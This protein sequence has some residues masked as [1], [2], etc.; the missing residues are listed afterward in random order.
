M[1]DATMTTALV[2][3]RQEQ[4]HIAVR[5]LLERVAGVHVASLVPDDKVMAIIAAVEK[6]RSGAGDRKAKAQSPKPDFKDPSWVQGV[7]Y[8]RWNRAGSAS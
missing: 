3:L 7:V 8:D 1:T 2:Q 5:N 4:G 6:T